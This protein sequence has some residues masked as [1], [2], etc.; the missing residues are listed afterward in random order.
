[1]AINTA[2]NKAIVELPMNNRIVCGNPSGKKLEA[3]TASVI[4]ITG[5]SAI[6][7]LG[8][9]GGNFLSTGFSSAKKKSRGIGLYVL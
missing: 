4:N 8:K 7:K 1:M 6:K 3:T 9:A 5:N 2:S